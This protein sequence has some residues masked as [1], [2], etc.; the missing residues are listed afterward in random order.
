[1]DTTPKYYTNMAG[2]RMASGA[3]SAPY[4]K[5]TQQSREVIKIIPLKKHHHPS[6]LYFVIKR[7]KQLVEVSNGHC[8]L[9]C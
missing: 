6:R 8:Y 5:K 4:L 9:K 1:M 2:F 3:K 7:I